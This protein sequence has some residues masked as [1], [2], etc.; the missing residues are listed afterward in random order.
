MRDHFGNQEWAQPEIG[1]PAFRQLEV[2]RTPPFLFPF[3]PELIQTGLIRH[4]HDL[5]GF[6]PLQPRWATG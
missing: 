4:A 3:V 6:R 1:E 2:G 5:S